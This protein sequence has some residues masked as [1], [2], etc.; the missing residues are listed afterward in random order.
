MLPGHRLVQ[1]PRRFQRRAGAVGGGHAAAGRDRG[2]L[3][4]P[5]AGG[6]ARGSD[7]RTAGL[8]P[9][10]R[11]RQPG[12]GRGHSRAWRRGHPGG[13]HVRQPRGAPP[14]NDGR[15]RI[16]ARPPLQR[17]ERD[18]RPGH[19]GAGAA[20]GRARPRGDRS[21]VRGRRPAFRHRD[22]GQ[23]PPRRG[24]GRGGRAGGGRRCL[25]DVEVGKHSDAHGISRDSRRRRAHDRHR[26]A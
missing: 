22:L 14:R 11:G 10:P 13:H 20:R 19:R 24:Q 18:P 7:G 8:D 2:Q 25:P 12:Q 1:A 6:C 15:A 9:H 5:R 23:E 3:G 21:A 17:L 26:C 4:Q 16:R